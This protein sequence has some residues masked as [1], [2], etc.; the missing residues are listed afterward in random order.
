[1]SAVYCIV[2]LSAEHQDAVATEV[3][4]QYPGSMPVA[5]NVFLLTSGQ[6]AEQIAVALGIRPESSG[7][8][9][10]ERGAGLVVSL[11]GSFSGYGATS[12]G[13]WL[14]AHG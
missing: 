6:S 11:N 1:M 10:P 12:L 14:K 9:P 13:N 4:R 5:D 2:A 8:E 7:S 3:A